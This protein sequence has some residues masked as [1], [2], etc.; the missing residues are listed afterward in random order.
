M[1]PA[2]FRPGPGLAGQPPVRPREPRLPG[3]RPPTPPAAGEAGRWGD[4][5]ADPAAHGSPPAGLSRTRAAGGPRCPAGASWIS[6]GAGPAGI[7][8]RWGRPPAARGVRVHSLGNAAGPRALGALRAGSCS[9]P[10]RRRRWSPTRARSAR[11]NVRGPGRA[12]SL[13]PEE[14]PGCRPCE[15]VTSSAP[16]NGKPGLG[17]PSAAPPAAFCPLS[18]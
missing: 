8:R 7:R 14:P 2:S 18:T 9:Q 15:S 6:R 17:P 12:P 5:H 1:R 4:P 3:A 13:L 11:D 16:L 10:R